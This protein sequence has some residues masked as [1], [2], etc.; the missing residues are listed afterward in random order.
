MNAIA[1]I[2]QLRF[3][4]RN[5]NKLLDIPYFRMEPGERVFISGPSGVGKTT[6][7]GLIGGAFT[8]QQ[9]EIRILNQS[10]KSMKPA[11]RGQFRADHFGFLLPMPN[12]LPYLSALDNVALVIQ[13]SPRKTEKVGNYFA[14]R[15]TAGKLLIKMGLHDQSLWYK[16]PPE[17]TAFQQQQVMF[18]R[19]LIG[20][21]ELIIADEPSID[22]DAK[23]RD[24]LLSSLLNECQA[25]QISLIYAGQRPHLRE[26]F[27][28]CLSIDE[29][30]SK[31]GT[32]LRA[33]A[34]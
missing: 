1:E 6:L 8:P 34:V 7:L 33:R 28:R 27:D 13:L 23:Q 16:K 24:Q 4:W 17:L 12:L 25:K 5:Q 32:A 3:A 29:L 22:A 14:Q 26:H 15:E 19:A 18:A 20:L 30:Q 31:H 9:G 11:A 21:P 2:S 10:F